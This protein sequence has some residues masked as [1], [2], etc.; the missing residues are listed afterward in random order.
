MENSELRVHGCLRRCTFHLTRFKYH[1][2]RILTAHLRVGITHAGRGLTLMEKLPGGPSLEEV[3]HRQMECRHLEEL[4][5]RLSE[6]EYLALRI[7]SGLM[8]GRPRSLTRTGL[9]LG[10]SRERVRQIERRALKRL[11]EWIEEEERRG[12][13]VLERL[14]GGKWS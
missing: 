11:R 13:E 12:A 14:R 3:L 2:E 5:Q 10:V 1:H 4:M 6:R 9:F 7:R 8:D